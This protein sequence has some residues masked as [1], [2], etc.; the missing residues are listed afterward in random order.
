MWKSMKKW[1]N[2]FPDPEN[3]VENLASKS[4]LF[5]EMTVNIAKTSFKIKKMTEY[6]C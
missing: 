4:I 5:R 6:L 1:K 3:Y 2:N